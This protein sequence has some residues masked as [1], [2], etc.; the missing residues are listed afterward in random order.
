[1]KTLKLL[2]ISFFL[3][4]QLNAQI[5]LVVNTIP[6]DI[7]RSITIPVDTVALARSFAYGKDFERADYLLTKYNLNH[8]DISGLGL[9]AQV[10]YWMKA[11]DRSI[12]T[13]KKATR[14]FPTSSIQL[15][16][17]RMLFSLNKLKEA[18]SLLNA[19]MRYDS[20]NVDANIMTAY[21]NVW[22]GRTGLAAKKASTV[23]QRYPD[24][25]EAKDILNQISNYTTPYFKTGTEYFSDDQ[26]LEG[27]SFYAEA[28][29]YKSWL[30][31]PTVHASAYQ[32][33]SEYTLFHS[34]WAQASNTVQ[35]GMKSKIKLKG[36]IFQQNSVGKPFTGGIEVSRKIARNFLLQAGMEKRPYQYTVRSLNRLVMEN[37][38]GVSLSYNKKDKWLGK[39]GYELFR[40][41]DANKINAAYLWVLGPVFSRG[42]FSLS[43]GYGFR[44]ADA[45]DS[46]YVSQKS[47]SQLTSSVY[48]G[49]QGVYSPYFTPEEQ[50]IHS[51]LASVK[52]SP[53]KNLQFSSRA[54]IGVV[55][56]AANPY[57]WL[58]RYGGEY[59]IYREYSLVAFKPA[60]L[61]KN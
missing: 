40:Y 29:M 53:V 20:T 37:F 9:H 52:F 14:L 31:A 4:S 17:A 28:G 43:G 1:M 59:T 55:A 12:D 24:H 46:R 38:S 25:A 36:G 21:I 58:D 11:Y 51:A 22:N 50:K 18:R 19:Y 3:V 8:S 34:M 61:V 6:T 48:K 32:Y 35:L 27:S 7:V 44:Y 57:L 30:F 54:T 41:Q 47:L 45:V 56:K 42:H 10:L 49:V 23:L 60:T 13:Y 16:Y 39:A 26:P 33:R 5:N 15:E 2:L